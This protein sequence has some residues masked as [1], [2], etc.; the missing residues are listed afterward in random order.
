ML[1]DSVVRGEALDLDSILRILDTTSETLEMNRRLEQ[2]SR[3]LARIG[4]ELRE[5][6]ARLRELDRLKDE[7]VAMVSH[8]LRTPLT[9]IRAFAEILRDN[10]ELPQQRREHFLDVV[11][12]ES[13]R[14]SR[15]IEEILDLARLESGRLPLEPQR[16]IW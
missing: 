10:H 16:W 13:Q 15:L 4:Q 3:E 14:L 2:K 11:V 1:I 12:R 5:A 9:S 8:E 6:N 7:F